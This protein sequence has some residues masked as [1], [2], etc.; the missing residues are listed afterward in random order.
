MANNKFTQVLTPVGEVFWAKLLTQEEY[1]GVATGKYSALLKFSHEDTIK[2][3]EML[4][5]EYESLRKSDKNL[6]ELKPKKG[7]C[8]TFGEKEDAEGNISFKFTTKAEFKNPK[9]DQVMKRTVP[10]FDSQGKPMVGVELGNGSL[11]VFAVSLAPKCISNTNY[12]ISLWLDG[13]QVR[14]LVKYGQGSQTA[15]AFGF[16]VVEDGYKA[17]EDCEV[18]ASELFD[19]ADND[20]CEE[21]DAPI[22]AKGNF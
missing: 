21:V 4:E 22:G 10:M 18:D 16:G 8:P 9:T 15:N 14:S 5:K 20:E 11:C 3:Q 1:K 2:F 17:D 19:S 7:S 12:G 13:V 6:M